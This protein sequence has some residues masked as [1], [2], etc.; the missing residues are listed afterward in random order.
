M[1]LSVGPYHA[2][3]SL[4]GFPLVSHLRNPLLPLVVE[5]EASTGASRAT[6][7][8]LHSFLKDRSVSGKLNCG[9][10]TENNIVIDGSSEREVRLRTGGYRTRK[11]GP[12]S[13]NPCPPRR[14]AYVSRR[15]FSLTSPP[16]AFPRR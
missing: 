7:E 15:V 8:L 13:A 4:L 5:Q 3:Q 12:G 6:V 11:G 1:R 2:V 9:L 10:Q 16:V 14:F